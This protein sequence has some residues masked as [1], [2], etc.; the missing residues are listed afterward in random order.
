MYP[1][2]TSTISSFTQFLSISAH[3]FRP[4]DKVEIDVNERTAL[5][6]AE[7]NDLYKI[8]GVEA[9]KSRFSSLP[10]QVVR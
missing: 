1:R 4:A 5:T 7:N 2:V 9:E 3:S 10:L 8:E 6:Q